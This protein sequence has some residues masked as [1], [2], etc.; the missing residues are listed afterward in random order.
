MIEMQRNPRNTGSS[1]NIFKPLN[2]WP[3]S[4]KCLNKHK[5]QDRFAWTTWH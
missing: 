2:P 3:W 4:I 1:G 5:K